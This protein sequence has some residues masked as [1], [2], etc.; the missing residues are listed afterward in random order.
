MN[1]FGI[2]PN[3]NFLFFFLKSLYLN[4]IKN[5]FFDEVVLKKEAKHPK[6]CEF[7]F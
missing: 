5:L 6:G 1:L 3:I 7:L 2:K 4:L